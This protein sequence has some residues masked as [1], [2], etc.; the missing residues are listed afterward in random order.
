VRRHDEG[1]FISIFS[2]KGSPGILMCNAALP[3]VL[4][5]ERRRNWRR[6]QILKS[7]LLTSRSLGRE[8]ALHKAFRRFYGV[9]KPNTITMSGARKRVRCV[10]T[11][12][13]FT[14]HCPSGATSSTARLPMRQ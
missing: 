7:A 3:V 4:L 14:I 11:K 13:H 8:W 1:C 12:L 6:A 10:C 2:I 5:F 9:M